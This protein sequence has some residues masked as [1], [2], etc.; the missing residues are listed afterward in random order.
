[1]IYVNSFRADFPSIKQPLI[2]V[3]RGL[4]DLALVLGNFHV[5]EDKEGSDKRSTIGV[6]PE[7]WKSHPI[8]FR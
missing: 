5:R 8:V 4:I 3:G 2:E 1:M 7:S 6:W